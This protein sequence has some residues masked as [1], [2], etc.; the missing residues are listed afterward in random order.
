[1]SVLVSSSSTTSHHYFSNPHVNENVSS[2]RKQAS[3]TYRSTPKLNETTNGHIEND[4][5]PYGVV[6]SM[7]Q[8]LFDKVNESLLSNNNSIVARHS[9]SKPSLRISSNENLL[10]TKSLTSPLKQAARLSRSQ[11]N[12]INAEPFASYLQP[13]QDVIIVERTKSDDEILAASRHSYTE[14]HID[15]V[16][17]PGTVT[18]VKKIFERQIR[19]SRYDSD[20]IPN[21]P[22]LHN[23]R[24]NSQHRETSSPTRS[25]S[26]S[27]NDMALRQRRTTTTTVAHTST[28]VPSVSVPVSTSYPDVV[29][30]HTPP[31]TIHIETHKTISDASINSEN[32]RK[33]SPLKKT[34]DETTNTTVNQN[35]R[36]VL[37]S[38]SSSSDNDEYQPLDFKSRL[39]LFNRTN[40]IEQTQINSHI[41]INKTKPSNH[42][43]TAAPSPPPTFLTKPVLHHHLDRKDNLL[44]AI[45]RPIVNTDKSVTFFGGAKVNGNLTSTLPVS[46][47]SPT[48]PATKDEQSPTST[49]TPTEATSTPDIIGGNVKLNKSSIFSGSK[50]DTRVQFID[51]VDTFEYPSYNA[52][53]AEFGI[54][55]SDENEDDDDDDYEDDL[56][57]QNGTNS[58]QNNNLN[59]KIIHS[60]DDVDDDELE[61]LASINAK[62]NSNAQTDKT[63]QSKGT[64]HTFR[65]NYLDQYELGTQHDS[66]TSSHSS[67]KF[68]REN[69]FS[70]PGN[71]SNHS[72]S[73]QEKPMVDMTNNIQWS[74]MSTTTDLLF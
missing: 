41:S 4:H 14:L 48:L 25:R 18:T 46:V 55:L 10:Q 61:E 33:I 39:A 32:K 37:V 50:K 40:T 8:R 12:L 23:S 15:E 65:P 35:R 56:S 74:S 6:N 22:V 67:D 69:Y 57:N 2:T 1:M 60:I 30:S 44:D 58:I 7:K 51:S 38:T 27:P 5:V 21:T 68:S 28:L 43:K 73:K 64:L 54:S 72:V 20:K 66:I 63:L 26:T 31:A 59:G 62:F 45:A 34:N 36:N 17:K 13:K 3:L 47:P 52:T 49:P 24:M 16:P 19:L 42:S 9:L 71:Y 29:I 53:M 11:D 70:S